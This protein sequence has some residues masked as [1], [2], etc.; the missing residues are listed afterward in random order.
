[1]AEQLRHYPTPS[2]LIA[3]GTKNRPQYHLGGST[4]NTAPPT[5]NWTP[6]TVNAAPPTV[7][8]A[9]PRT[10]RVYS[11]RSQ[12]HSYFLSVSND[13]SKKKKWT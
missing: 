1:M 9:P 10:S 3:I 8:W 13:F 5:V 7:N 12:G 2:G 11:R 6:P 4:V